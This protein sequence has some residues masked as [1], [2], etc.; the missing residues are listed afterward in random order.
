MCKSTL[1][2]HLK[3]APMTFIFKEIVLLELQNENLISFDTL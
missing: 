1:L 2:L 3:L